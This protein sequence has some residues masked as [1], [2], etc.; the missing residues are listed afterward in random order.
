M[1]VVVDPEKGS[2]YMN[3]AKGMVLR[4]VTC[5]HLETRAVHA[6]PAPSI[7]ERG[8]WMPAPGSSVT[9]AVSRDH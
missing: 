1:V 8:R 6:L 7:A 4:D 2:R 5:S 3:T 9:T